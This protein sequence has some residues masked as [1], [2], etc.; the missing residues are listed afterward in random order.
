M[1]ML[2]E[3]TYQSLLLR[4]VLAVVIGA[5]LG[6]ERG[7]RNRPAGLR[8]YMLV[9]LGSAIVMM[10]NQYIYQ[11]CNTG[12]PVRMGA[13]VI[14]GIGFLGAGTII[15]TQR[16]QIRGITTAA[17]LWTSAC[18]GLAIGIGFYE[19]AI[20]GGGTVLLIL[21]VMQRLDAKM[22]HTKN[23]Y[24]IY[25]ELKS[26]HSIV[27]FVQYMRKNN[28]AISNFQFETEDLANGE[29]AYFLVTIKCD[30]SCSYIKMQ[31]ILNNI[32]DLI[33][34]QEL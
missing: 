23:V 22:K 4:T 34:V 3:L 21:S 11:C 10:T 24:D 13:Q 20:L 18:L 14:S 8:T 26:K 6:I 5:I 7:K 29:C 12:D 17:A 32:P 2:R 15:V 9:C 16:N 31:E 33:F 27:K 19:I 30:K 25:V 28:F 1:M